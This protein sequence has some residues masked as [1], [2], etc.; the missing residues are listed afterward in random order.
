MMQERIESKW[1]GAFTEVFR[2]CGVQP[3]ECAVIVSEA[4]SRPVN[5]H[6]AERMRSYF[7]A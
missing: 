5:A 3:G 7:A 1:I 4:Q 6:L 2:L